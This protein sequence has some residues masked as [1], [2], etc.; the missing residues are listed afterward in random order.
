MV[1]TQ[2]HFVLVHGTGHGA[3][4]WY[5]LKP[6]LESGGHKVTALDLAASGV[7]PKQLHHLRTL[8]DYNLP[9]MEFMSAL[10]DGEKVILVGHSFGGINIALAMENYPHKISVAVFIAAF[11][12][13]SVHSPSYVLDQFNERTPAETWMDTQFVPYGTPEDPLTAVFFGAR[14]LSEKLY[15]LCSPED[16][17]LGGLLIRPSSYFTE[18]FSKIKKFTDEGYGSVKRAFIICSKD[19]AMLL[20]FQHW[21][22]ENTGVSQV[23]EIK[24]ADHMAMLSKPQQLCQYLLEIAGDE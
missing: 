23:K 4:C 24:D 5:K 20:E 22:I 21:L 12:P 6:L 17:A 7:N 8:H 16:I 15:Q 9:L 3:W 18:D 14:F 19:E 10:P 13:D 11:M 2:K 1:M